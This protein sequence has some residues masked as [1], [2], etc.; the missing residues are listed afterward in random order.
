M[1]AD[2]T[3]QILDRVI[4]AVVQEFDPGVGAHDRVEELRVGRRL[5]G[6]QGIGR[7]CGWSLGDP[8]KVDGLRRLIDRPALRTLQGQPEAAF[9]DFDPPE[10]ADQEV[11]Q[12]FIV[13]GVV[14]EM[15]GHEPCDDFLDCDSLNA[16]DRTDLGFAAFQKG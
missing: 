11:A 5:G 1:Q 2:G 13:G 10:G 4:S 8:G 7:C 12:A 9:A 6:G 15:L 14:L 3:G 16:S